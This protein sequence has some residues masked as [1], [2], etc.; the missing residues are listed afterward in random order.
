MS[1]GPIMYYYYIR[2]YQIYL[3]Y[4]PVILILYLLLKYK[5]FDITKLGGY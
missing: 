4:F 1:K 5:E 3:N 2:G